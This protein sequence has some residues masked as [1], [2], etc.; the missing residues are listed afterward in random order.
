MVGLTLIMDE[1]DPTSDEY[2]YFA[3]IF[4]KMSAEFL[5]IQLDA[6]H[7]SM[8]LLSGDVYPTL[9]TSGTSFITFGTGMGY[10]PWPARHGY[11]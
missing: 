1:L 9:E 6:G 3:E 5:K 7:W 2:Q 10:Q 4:R 8:S 11:L